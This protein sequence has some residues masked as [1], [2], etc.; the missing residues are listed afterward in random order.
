[1]DADQSMP[2][3]LSRRS[4]QFSAARPRSTMGA[5]PCGQTP[6]GGEILGAG[7]IRISAITR[8][9][10]GFADRRPVDLD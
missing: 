5:W 8:R 10:T 4:P 7:V 1:M 9:A 2:Q 3:H 6:L